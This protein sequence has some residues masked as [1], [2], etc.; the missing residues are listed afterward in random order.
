MTLVSLGKFHPVMDDLLAWLDDTDR[1]I[2]TS[3]PAYG[4]PKQI[5]A[6]L[7][8]LKVSCSNNFYKLI[9]LKISISLVY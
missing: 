1:S 6:E 5:E 3:T 4:D 8:K 2:D 9:F 7:S